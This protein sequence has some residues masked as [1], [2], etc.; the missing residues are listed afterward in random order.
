MLAASPLFLNTY[1]VDVLNSVGLY[2]IL[3][4]SLNITLGQ[5]G[6]FNLGHAAFYAVGAYTA[7]ILNTRYQIPIMW[8]LPVCAHDA[9]AIFAADRRAPHHSPARRLSVHRHRRRGRDRPH[10]PD[11]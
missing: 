6:L 9:A 11:Q 7:A 4:L 10:C 2:A 8:L 3:G 1:W 5:A